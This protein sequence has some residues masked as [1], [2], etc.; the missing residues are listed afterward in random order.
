MT[1]DTGDGRPPRVPQRPDAGP[2][3]SLPSE[4]PT[5]SRNEPMPVIGDPASTPGQEVATPTSGAPV[6][7]GGPTPMNAIFSDLKRS[8]HWVVPSHMR[9]RVIF[10][11]AYLDLREAQI[12]PGQTRIDLHLVC[13]DVKILVPPG[14]A[15]DVQGSIGLGDTKIDLG[16]HPFEDG[17]SLL[18]TVT[19]VMA[20]LK[21][22]ALAPG[23]KV[24]RSWKWF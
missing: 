15:V 11:D 9:S 20:D 7:Y 14:L 23:R 8:G 13:G 16:S 4:R 2:Q 3:D 6:P 17:T 5:P 1:W 18:I 21:V 12:A 19:G 24:S 22:K 10:G